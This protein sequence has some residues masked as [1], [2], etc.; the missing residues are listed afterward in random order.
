[1]PV[2]TSSPA[3]RCLFLCAG[4][5]ACDR[6]APAGPPPLPE[7]VSAVA[8][9]GNEY[10]TVEDLQEQI[11]H[12]SPFM[13]LRYSTP[14]K[15]REF[16]D[17]L[18][19][20][21]VMAADA[22][23][24]GY[25]NDPDIV[26]TFKQ[27]MVARLIQKEFEP[28]HDPSQLSE[29]EVKA[30]YDANANKFNDPEE[31]DW[32]QIVVADEKTA[33]QVMTDAKKLRPDDKAG[34]ESLVARYSIDKASKERGGEMGPLK[35]TDKRLPPEMLKPLFEAKA[36]GSMLGPYKTTV[37]FVVIRLNGIQPAVTR[38][39][40]NAEA[41]ARSFLFKEVR[42]KALVDWVSGLR[43]R[44]DVKIFDENLGKVHVDT[45]NAPPKLN[46]PPVVKYLDQILPGKAP[47][48]GESP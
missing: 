9:V 16:L 3:L 47:S 20:F 27:Q 28:Q 38:N 18:I 37:G 39:Y 2:P 44:S 32:S 11:N 43:A 30:Y 31:R 23:A 14:E 26:R 7:G 8:R 36:A 40:E 17:N 29:E 15:K 24:K 45:T 34:F 22:R 21:E 33:A 46:D 35:A 42:Q 13:R 25:T 19:R 5:M 41:L 6:G 12:E 4:L 48:P 1:M 10:I